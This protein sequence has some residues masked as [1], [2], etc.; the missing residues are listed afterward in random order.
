MKTNL[1]LNLSK[2]ARRVSASRW[3]VVPIVASAA[4]ATAAF[5]ADA[6]LLNVVNLQADSTVEVA[7]DVL[8]LTFTTTRE[9]TD[10]ATV[11]SGLKQA[12]DAALTEA[13]AV[14]KPDGQVDVHTGNFSLYPRYAAAPK[15]GITGWQG[16][17]ELIVEGKDMAAISQL[18]G[19]ISTMTIGRVTTTLSR[20]QRD[21]VEADVTGQAIAKYQAKAAAYAKQ[22]GFTGYQIREVNVSMNEASP[23]M[24]P[25]Q[26]RAKSMLASDE[27]L[28]VEAGKGSVT[29]M[30]N[31]SVVMTK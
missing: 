20:A 14:A 19:R 31:G 3:A 11:Q 17:A 18:S 28:P 27:P 23:F 25:M 15:S 30:V 7:K 9:G 13:K 16:S 4:F 5:A 2:T 8:S 12:L 29:A 22:F 1:C 6:P 10:A 24:A 26:M 21:K